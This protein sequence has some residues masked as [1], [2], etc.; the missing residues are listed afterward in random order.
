MLVWCSRWQCP[1]KK[2]LLVQS[3]SPGYVPIAFEGKKVNA[4]SC[5][6]WCYMGTVTNS[7]AAWRY[8]LMIYSAWGQAR[9]IMVVL[10]LSP[11]IWCYRE[12]IF[13]SWD[14]QLLA[15]NTIAFFFSPLSSQKSLKMRTCW[16]VHSDGDFKCTKRQKCL[17][18][19]Y[20]L[21][22]YNNEK[23]WL[24]SFTLDSSYSLWLT[25]I[26][27]A[28][29][30]LN[31]VKTNVRFQLFPQPKRKSQSISIQPMYFEKLLIIEKPPSCIQYFHAQ[32]FLLSNIINLTIY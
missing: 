16:N 14:K 17:N 19:A 31:L 28:K 9:G 29:M 18:P 12:L 21:S 15:H 11:N 22:L 27:Q 10:K 30:K 26:T 25:V 32:S 5:V 13:I 2:D 1:E 7:K 8:S 6:A 3:P 20:W 24:N 4:S 23:H